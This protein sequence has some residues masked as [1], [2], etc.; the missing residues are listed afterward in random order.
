M[1]HGDIAVCGEKWWG[2]KYVCDKCKIKHLEKLHATSSDDGKGE[3]EIRENQT[4][5]VYGDI[6]GFDINT[7][8]EIEV[9]GKTTTHHSTHS[10]RTKEKATR[11]GLIAL[12]WTPPENE[13]KGLLESILD[14]IKTHHEE[15]PTHGHNCICMDK[16]A[17]SIRRL[18]SEKGFTGA[19]KE[20]MS[21]HTI[22][23]YLR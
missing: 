11:E 6:E 18:L 16:H 4:V 23:S 7:E 1:G 10:I 15:N 5:T 8:T 17:A 3:N 19:S 14:E 2:E 20:A 12:G 13:N 22:I 9:W 21:F